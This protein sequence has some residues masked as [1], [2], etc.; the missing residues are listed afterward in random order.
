MAIEQHSINYI[1]ESDRYGKP[2]DLFAVW[3]GANLNLTTIVTG[4][5]LVMMG[6]NLFWSIA[7][8]VL[9]NAIGTVFVAS[10]SVQGP[11]LGI[12]QMIQSRAQFGVL[13]AIIPMFFVMFVY[14]GFGVANTLLISQTLNNVL[15]ISSTWIIILFTFISIFIAI[16]GYRL[17][18]F[19]QKWLSISAFVV[20]GIA[21]IMAFNQ[22]LP[23]GAWNISAFN[24]TLFV[25]GVGII[26]TYVLAMAPYV[27]D[28]SRYLPSD[29]S[30]P[31][32]FWF[33]YS[34]LAISGSWMMTIGAALATVIPGFS[35][36]A[37]GKMADMFHGYS[38]L[39][40]ILIVYGLFA[41][42][43]FNFYG[44][45]MSVVTSI[46]PFN[47]LKVTPRV[48][49]IILGA[50]LVINI[51]LSLLGGE[52]N[53]MTLFINFIYFM[54][55]FLIPWTAINLLDFFVLRKG[56][57]H[58]QDIFDVHGRYGKYNKITIFAFLIA[59]VAEIPFINSTFYVGPIAKMLDGAD[60][61]WIVGIVAA[62]VLY[63][64]PMKNWQPAH[65]SR[66]A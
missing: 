18:H 17:I 54:S 66:K 27:A 43:V 32:V 5:V 33:T 63:Y 40:Y 15:P 55:Y 56:H 35:D 61:A 44:A 28:Y 21:T 25:S 46:Q 3:F 2:K 29:V 4:A 41:I 23:A 52:S 47:S 49:T 16:Y 34:G 22:P 36:N 60:M 14:L 57:Y 10:H 8:I 53:F 45:F 59:I 48:R 42:N 50:I 51:V 19:T 64:F 38:W 30:S 24:L 37:G 13:G 65:V 12:P 9:G 62:L 31:K 39:M 6:L 7:A 58:I 20:L 11:R 1:P 26:A